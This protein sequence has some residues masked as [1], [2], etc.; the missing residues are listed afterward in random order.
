MKVGQ[1]EKPSA[2]HCFA[3]HQPAIQ[4]MWANRYSNTLTDTFARLDG[5]TNIYSHP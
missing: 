5:D 4:R 2:S 1:Y 3:G